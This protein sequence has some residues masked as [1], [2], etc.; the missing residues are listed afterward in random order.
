MPS[1]ESPPTSSRTAFA[2]VT[3]ERVTRAPPAPGELGRAVLSEAIERLVGAE[4]LCERRLLRAP[5]DGD[6]SEPHLR[7][8]RH[9]E[10]AQAS[11]TQDRDDVPGTGAARPEG[12]ERGDPGAHIIGA[13]S[14]GLS[15]I[16]TVASPSNGATMNSAYPPSNASP[17]MRCW[18]LENISPRWQVAQEPSW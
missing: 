2:S 5:G 6:R 17:V 15:S 7:G 1:A 4:L 3:V 8:V 18:E 10:M 11:E 12:V 13:A 9:R 14:T 16:G